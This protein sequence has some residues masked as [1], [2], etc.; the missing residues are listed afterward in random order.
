MER[1]GLMQRASTVCL[2]FATTWMMTCPPVLTWQ[3]A[4]ESICIR[5]IKG[6]LVLSFSSPLLRLK[7]K[8]VDITVRKSSKDSSS[9]SSKKKK[10]KKSS[11]PRSAASAAA[12]SFGRWILLHRLIKT[13]QVSVFDITVKSQQVNLSWSTQRCVQVL[14]PRSATSAV[15]GPFLGSNP[16]EKSD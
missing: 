1:N 14:T 13:V 11:G 16:V 10:K 5:E 4:I 7:V 6:Q 15:D 3:G 2:Y 8:D 12:A 9:S